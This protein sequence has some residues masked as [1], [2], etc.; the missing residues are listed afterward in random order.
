M[1]TWQEAPEALRR[2]I[3]ALELVPADE[4]LAALRGLADA[5]GMELAEEV[6]RILVARKVARRRVAQMSDSQI[7]AR[8][9][10]IMG[11]AVDAGQLTQQAMAEVMAAADL[12]AKMIEFIANG[13]L[14]ASPKPTQEL[15]RM[16]RGET[17]TDALD[18]DGE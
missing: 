6:A 18:E 15:R 14:R 2:A 17:G 5:Q 13:H 12:R 8:A 16:L 7:R 10:E 9:Q 3:E 4:Q 11:A 1:Q